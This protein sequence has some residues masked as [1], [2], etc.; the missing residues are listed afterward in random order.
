MPSGYQNR[1]SDT[2]WSGTN[3][4]WTG[5]AWSIVAQS[6]FRLAKTASFDNSTRE[7][8]VRLTVQNARWIDLYEDGTF[9]KRYL[10]AGIANQQVVVRFTSIASYFEFQFDGTS[11]SATVTDI[12]VGYVG[13]H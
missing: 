11:R 4:T 7:I 3:A 13:L 1:L 9:L 12:E 10:L 2:Y 6:S 8:L 5:S